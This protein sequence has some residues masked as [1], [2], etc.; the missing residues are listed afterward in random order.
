MAA[1]EAGADPGRVA[2]EALADDVRAELAQD[3]GGGL[4]FEQELERR[5]DEFPAGDVTAAEVRGKPGGHTHLVAGTG[6]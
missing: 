6:R 4:A 2:G 3:L 1:A 5:P